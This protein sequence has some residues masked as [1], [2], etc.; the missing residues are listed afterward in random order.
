MTDFSKFRSLWNIIP[1]LFNYIQNPPQKYDNP[2]YRFGSNRKVAI[3]CIHGTGDRYTAFAKAAKY[4]Q[5]K[6]PEYFSCIHLVKFY[7]NFKQNEISVFAEKLMKQ[8]G[9]NGDKEVVLIGH[10][11]G[12]LV[13]SYAAEYLSRKYEIAVRIVIAIV[14]PYRG[15]W[16]AKLPVLNRLTSI[17]QMQSGHDFLME[18]SKHINHSHNAMKKYTRYLFIGAK[19]DKIVHGSAFLP[20]GIH[21]KDKEN[22][23][24]FP[25]DGHLS[26]LLNKD[27]YEV[28]LNQLHASE[29]RFL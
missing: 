17:Q 5:A 21:E 26:I 14:V 6:L 3:Y 23:Y 2:N 29:T 11:R 9:I 24:Q 10:S 16:W 18:L 7:G 28:I 20:Y 19:R 1:Y 15:S 22:V 27:L 4:M 8:I 13:A 25:Y 12:G